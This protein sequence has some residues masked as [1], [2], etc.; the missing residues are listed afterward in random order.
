MERTNKVAEIKLDP[1]T[2]NSAVKQ[3]KSEYTQLQLDQY[4]FVGGANNFKAL[5]GC[6]SK[7]N[8][9]GCMIKA[10]FTHKGKTSGKTIDLLKKDS[11]L[12]EV[13]VDRNGC[14]QESYDPFTFTG[15]GAKFTVNTG[16]PSKMVGSFKFRTYKDK[17]ILLK[18]TN[19]EISYGE[20]VVTLAATVDGSKPSGT[21]SFSGTKVN[22]GNWHSLWFEVSSN[23]F[24]LI[25]DGQTSPQTSADIKSGFFKSPTVFGKDFIGCM[26]DI[27]INDNKHH[28]QSVSES[29][30]P[31]VELHKCNIFDFCFPNP[32]QN[33]GEC[34][35]D[36]RTFKCKCSQYEG[37]QGKICQF[38]EYEPLVAGAAI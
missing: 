19:L 16:S 26:R 23:K 29:E 36:G 18:Q 33:N 11:L 14:P 9:M 30:R 22:S 32:C 35:Q 6:K 3:V 7:T 4:I 21:V 37:Y 13:G 34:D 2:S 31:K 1:T 15:T 27:V 12:T 10:S 24:E 28:P 8:F 5:Q 17:G 20:S 25:V 38:R